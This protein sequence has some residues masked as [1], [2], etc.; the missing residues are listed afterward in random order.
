MPMMIMVVRLRANRRLRLLHH[1]GAMRSIAGLHREWNPYSESARAQ[2]RRWPVPGRS[3]ACEDECADVARRTAA[4]ACLRICDLSDRL[5]HGTIG[6][7]YAP[8]NVQTG[9]PSFLALSARLAEMPE[10]GKTMT[11]IGS[12]SRI[13]SLRLKGAALAWRA[14]SGLNTTCG[15][16][17][18]SARRAAMRSAPLGDPPCSS[19]ISGCLARTLSSLSQIA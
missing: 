4:S 2:A 18:W 1:H 3:K 19:T 11:P 15:T 5:Q 12:T 9:M 7:A 16:L 13:W 8:P 10:P 14:Q 17:R 6:G